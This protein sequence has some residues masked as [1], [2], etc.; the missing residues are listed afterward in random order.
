MQSFFE[1]LKRRN[2]IRVGAAYLVASWLVVQLVETIFPAFGFGDGA[3]R[4]AVLIMG[5]GAVPVLILAWAFEITPEGVKR[6][7][8]VDRSQSITSQTGQKLNRAFI[9]LLIASLGFFAVDKFS[10]APERVKAELAR[11]RQEGANQAA[12]AAQAQDNAGQAPAAIPSKAQSVA[13]LPFVAMSR[14]EDDEY[15]A[16]GLTEEILNA[17]A[18]LPELLVTARISAFFFNLP[19]FTGLTYEEASRLPVTELA[20]RFVEQYPYHHKPA[21]WYDEE[22]KSALGIDVYDHAFPQDTGFLV[23]EHGNVRLLT[24]KIEMDRARQASILADFVGIDKLKMVSSQTADSKPY[25]EIYRA[26]TGE[27]ILPETYVNQMCST[28]YVTHFYS[29]AEIARIR[30]KWFRCDPQ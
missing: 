7:N 20:A 11:A 3:V 16:D 17:L 5:V 10:L 25:R 28:R 4:I 13:V 8:E 27:A 22:F 21:D 9:I 14:G 29:D 12:E 30:E 23:T 19:T 1:E 15:F 6:E 2:V 18:Q 26:F 24:I